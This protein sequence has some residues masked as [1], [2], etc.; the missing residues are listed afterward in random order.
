MTLRLTALRNSFLGALRTKT[1]LPTAVRE[2]AICRVAVLNKAWY[3]WESHSPILATGEGESTTTS[4]STSPSYD[5]SFLFN[6]KKSLLCIPISTRPPSNSYPCS[7][8]VISSLKIQYLHLLTPYVLQTCTRCCRHLT[9]IQ[10]SHQPTSPP[11]ST[12]HPA[13]QAQI[14]TPPP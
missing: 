12:P 14:S 4:M 13:P 7:F 5:E 8:A 3:E 2:T 1:S 10:E 6:S 11:F 9:P